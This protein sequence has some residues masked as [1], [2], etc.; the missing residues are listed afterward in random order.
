MKPDQL[1]KR[2]GKLGLI[3][4]NVDL[5][6]ARTFIDENLAREISVG[7]HCKLPIF[8]NSLFSQIGRTTGKL[9]NFIIEPFVKHENADEMYICIHSNRDGEVILFH[10]QGGIDIGDVDSKAL[11]YSIPIDEKF[12]ATKMETSLLK[13][14]SNDRRS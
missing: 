8:F 4:A 10:H 7:T 3:K 14:V 2:R 12:D 1:I 6:K 11:T 5:T 9:K 13:N